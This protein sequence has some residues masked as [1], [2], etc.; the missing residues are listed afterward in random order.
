MWR[1]APDFASVCVVC[2]PKVCKGLG[3]AKVAWLEQ[4]ALTSILLDDV[5]LALHGD[6]VFALLGHTLQAVLCCDVCRYQGCG[7]LCVHLTADTAFHHGVGGD[8]PRPPCNNSGPSK[9]RGTRRRLGLSLVFV[10]VGRTGSAIGA[11]VDGRVDGDLTALQPGRGQSVG[12]GCGA[13]GYK[14][15]CFWVASLSSEARGGLWFSMALV[16]VTATSSCRL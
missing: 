11:V 13:Q 3:W 15:I 5:C 9:L 6:H 10:V 12:C 16:F 8:P 7:S 1:V 14:T 4:E 2:L